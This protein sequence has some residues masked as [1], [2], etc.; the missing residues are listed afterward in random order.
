MGSQ[1]FQVNTHHIFLSIPSNILKADSADNLA[2]YFTENM[3]S[4]GKRLFAS[5]SKF[6]TYIP[7]YLNILCSH[8]MKHPIVLFL[9]RALFDLFQV[10]LLKDFCSCRYI[11]FFLHHQNFPIKE[12]F[13]LTYKRNIFHVQ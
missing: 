11:T 12:L 9:L 3:Q 7:V 5:A 8:A 4:M 10:L 2:F 6:T 13:P 1:H